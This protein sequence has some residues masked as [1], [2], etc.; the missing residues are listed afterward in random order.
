MNVIAGQSPAAHGAE[1]EVCTHDGACGVS[2]WL[3][4]EHHKDQLPVQQNEQAW[5]LQTKCAGID[6]SRKTEGSCYDQA[7]HNNTQVNTQANQHLNTR[8]N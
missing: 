5:A 1:V 6:E 8:G 3:A 7:T 4:L 2:G